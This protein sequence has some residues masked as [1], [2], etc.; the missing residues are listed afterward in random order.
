MKT[1]NM[2]QGI[3]WTP[4]IV[5][6]WPVWRTF[7][8]TLID[9][10]TSEVCYVGQTDDVPRRY[11][12]HLSWRDGNVLKVRWVNN[13]VTSELKP[14]MEV[15]EAVEPDRANQAERDA[16]WRFWNSGSPLLNQLESTK[17][18]PCVYY[19]RINESRIHT[20]RRIFDSYGPAARIESCYHCRRIRF[21]LRKWTDW[22]YNQ[23]VKARRS[24]RRITMISPY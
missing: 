22:A 1:P 7:I 13:L 14:I 23:G 5:D 19:K 20:E 4:K 8:Y 15:I 6:G 10:L 12:Q 9:P 18:P 21:A 2:I 11:T 3:D 17:L 24:K 16:I